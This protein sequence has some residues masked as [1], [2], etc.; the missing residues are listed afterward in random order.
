MKARWSRVPW[1]TQRKIGDSCKGE[2][3]DRG[4]KLSRGNGSWVGS[5]MRAAFQTLSFSLRAMERNHRRV[6]SGEP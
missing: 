1:Q 6:L 4:M 3:V 5:S 2:G